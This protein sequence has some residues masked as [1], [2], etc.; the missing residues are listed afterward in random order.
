VFYRE[1]GAQDAPVLLLPH[2]YP[3]SFYEF[4][5]LLPLQADRWRLLATDFPGC[6]YSFVGMNLAHAIQAKGRDR[7]LKQVGK[8]SSPRPLRF[9][10]SQRN[11]ALP[12]EAG[13]S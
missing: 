3:C 2:G 4:R 5:R 9:S 8:M 11:V 7:G 13:I 6:G 10:A 12:A 1:A